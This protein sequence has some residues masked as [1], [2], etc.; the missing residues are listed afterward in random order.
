MAKLTDEQKLSLA[1]N[2]E[3][4]EGGTAEIRMIKENL[5]SVSIILPDGR[6]VAELKVD[7]SLD[8]SWYGFNVNEG[9]YDL[10]IYNSKLYGSGNAK[11]EA[12]VYP[13]FNGEIHTTVSVQLN[14]KEE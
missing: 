5:Y 8:D 10:N 4:F 1:Q 7:D 3:M 11:W 13:V 12:T 6:K 2:I 9:E 14:V